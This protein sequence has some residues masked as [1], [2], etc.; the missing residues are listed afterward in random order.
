MS[1]D[2][3]TWHPSV[4]NIHS[5]QYSVASQ[6]LHALNSLRCVTPEIARLAVIQVPQTGLTSASSYVTE[7]VRR[8]YDV[9][10]GYLASL[11]A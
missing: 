3:R 2:D 9:S 7:T 6:A 10:L 5:S 1:G 11:V 8:L 4:L